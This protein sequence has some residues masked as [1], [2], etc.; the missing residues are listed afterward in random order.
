MS[1]EFKDN[2]MAVK[3]TLDA[4]I[5]AFLHSAAGELTSQVQNRTRVDHGNLKGS[6][7]YIVSN[8]GTKTV[9]TVGSPLENAIWE[10]F[11]TG[12]Y[13]LHGDGRKGGWYVPAEN[14]SAKA[15]SRMQRREIKGKV[16]Y[17][18]RGKTPS[19][20]FFTAY[21]ATKPKII[22]QAGQVI[23]AKMK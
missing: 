8:E 20:A 17:F 6:W 18:T 10:E 4:A 3:A 7:R 9:A 15:K 14:L 16:Y 19:R 5:T 22:K 11:G 12:E 1:V 23:G 2:S 13:A 21:T